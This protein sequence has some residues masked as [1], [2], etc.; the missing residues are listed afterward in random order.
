[1]FSG[2]SN[3]NFLQFVTLAGDSTISI[4]DSFVSFL[5]FEWHALIQIA[6]VPKYFKAIKLWAKMFGQ[7]LLTL[8]IVNNHSKC[9][10]IAP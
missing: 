10:H 4:A 3:T 6:S 1:M 8:S 2:L 7:L 5:Y 9:I